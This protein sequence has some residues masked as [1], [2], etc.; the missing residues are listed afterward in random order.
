MSQI[1]RAVTAGDVGVFDPDALGLDRCTPVEDFATLQLALDLDQPDLAV[2]STTLPGFDAAQR[3][4]A[5]RLTS[6]RTYIVV[7]VANAAERRAT[8]HA[9]AHVAV[10]AGAADDLDDALRAVVSKIRSDPHRRLVDRRRHDRG[11]PPDGTPDRRGIDWGPGQALFNRGE[12][13]EQ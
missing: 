6:P 1:V 9:G 11:A 8:E 7:V 10:D 2:V 5:L 4:A 3:I 13:P 12:Q